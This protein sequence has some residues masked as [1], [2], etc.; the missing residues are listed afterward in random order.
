MVFSNRNGA[1]DPLEGVALRL[2][3]R[4]MRALTV[5]SA[6]PGLSNSQVSERAG[7]KDQGQIS[8]LLA[9]LSRLGLI[10]NAGEGHAMGASNAW[11]LTPEGRH[12]EQ[13]VG[14]SLSIQAADGS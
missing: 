7:I 1:Q 9:R 2:T 5:I 11:H 14:A 12:L 13:R 10:E 8:K 4:T 3:Y 6:Q